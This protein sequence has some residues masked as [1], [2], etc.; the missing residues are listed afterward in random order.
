[1]T[2]KNF[3]AIAVPGEQTIVLSRTFDAPKRL[4]YTVCTTPAHMK[5]W[6]GPR[7]FT[8]PVCEI[9]LRVGGG[10]RYVQRSSEGQEFGF[11]GVYREIVPNERIVCTFVFEPM[12]E[13]EAVETMTL[14][15]NNG[16][17]TLTTTIWHA[18]VEARDGHF[19]SGMARG[20]EES[21]E[22]LAEI[23]ATLPN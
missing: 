10:Y 2:T 1:M 9:D 7:G 19:Q 13:H 6:W 4:V 21:F 14:V 23:I 18:S 3:Q 17:T 15:E 8:M 16:K 5:N 12:P 11:H 22:R 20:A